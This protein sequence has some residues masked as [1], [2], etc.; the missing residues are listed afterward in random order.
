MFGCF[1]KSYKINVHALKNQN[2]LIIGINFEAI[3]PNTPAKHKKVIGKLMDEAESRNVCLACSAKLVKS[4]E[5][6]LVVTPEAASFAC[7]L[8]ELSK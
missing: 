1:I 8:T 3:M 7:A 5:V 2:N 6:P 4:M